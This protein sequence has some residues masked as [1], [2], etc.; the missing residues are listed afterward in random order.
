M[1]EMVIFWKTLII[2]MSDD[3]FH[4][5]LG[6]MFTLYPRLSSH[7]VFFETLGLDDVITCKNCI[8]DQIKKCAKIF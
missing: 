8:S 7:Y 3:I 6:Q 2:F 1:S 4:P 5:E